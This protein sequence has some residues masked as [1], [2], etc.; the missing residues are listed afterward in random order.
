MHS[1][2]MG[3]HVSRY[4][5]INQCLLV[6]HWLN[7]IGLTQ[8]FLTLI[9]NGFDTMDKIA[10]ITQQD[11]NSIGITHEEHQIKMITN[12]LRTYNVEQEGK[13]D[14]DDNKGF[15]LIDAEGSSHQVTQFTT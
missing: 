3:A 6:K 1:C 8:Y 5:P 7:Q 15:Y 11:L 13:S 12:Q 9:E 14:V 2:T 10:N 4:V